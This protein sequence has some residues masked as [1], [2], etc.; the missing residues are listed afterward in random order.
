MTPLSIGS[1]GEIFAFPYVLEVLLV[2][3]FAAATALLASRA[4]F[5]TLQQSGYRARPFLRLTVSE[6]VRCKDRLRLTTTLGALGFLL[7][8]C[9][10]SFADANAVSFV[11]FLPFVGFFAWF[12]AKEAGKKEKSP[13]KNTPRMVRLKV[14][15]GVLFFLAAFALCMLGN[16][17]AYAAGSRFLSHVRYFPVVLLPYL[18][19]FVLVAAN[20]LLAPLEGAF[21]RKFI[22]K[23]RARLAESAAIKVGVT[24]SYGK[25]SVKNA[26]A[27]MLAEK[28]SVLA[29]PASYN[30]PLGICL[31]AE[32][33]DGKEV[34]IAE[35]GARRRGDIAELCE[36]VRPALGAV[37]SVGNQHLE[38]FGSAEAVLET[39][40]ELPAFMGESGFM[41]FGRDEGCRALY[42][43]CACR[44]VLAPEIKN[45]SVGERTRF[46]LCL[47]SGD[48]EC[49]TGLLGKFN[50]QNLAVAAALAEEMG[51]EPWQIAA[52][53]SKAPPVPHRL[54]R[55]DGANGG[56][57]L[58]DSYNSNPAGA[59]AALEVLCSFPGRKIVVTPGFVELGGE[60]KRENELLGRA[61]AA[62]D[63]VYLVGLLRTRPIREG[64]LYANFPAENIVVAASLEEAKEKLAKDAEAGDAVLFL[65]D[66]PDEYDE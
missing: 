56:V 37:V 46:T 27:A 28:Y 30:T 19:P 51:L 54:E 2:P 31:A 34:F 55:I 5:R 24:G 16:G 36:L 47:E 8:S 3:L 61:L 21:R 41:V 22:E 52:G 62:A 4:L 42:E 9:A 59:R 26:L 35:M 44:K 15:C 43:R 58:D 13:L 20:A 38:T 6:K 48:L 50:L 25:T 33:L 57:V 39:K 11:G 17:V 49:E 10:F 12:I 64:L 23:C 40:G 63:K 32:G 53:I 45:V 1:F 65:N 14:A 60:E 18:S 29:T 66:L 7:L